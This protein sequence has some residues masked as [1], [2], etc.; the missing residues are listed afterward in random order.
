MAAKFGAHIVVDTI[1]QA[2]IFRTTSPMSAL[3]GRQT[4]AAV[5]ISTAHIATVAE[6]PQRGFRAALAGGLGPD[7]IDLALAFEPEIV[8]V[9][10]HS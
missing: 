2:V 7:S 4:R 9:G 6:I 1:P 8:I 5:D 10:G 3:T